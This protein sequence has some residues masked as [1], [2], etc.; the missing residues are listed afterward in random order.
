[1]KDQDMPKA[2]FITSL[3][4]IGLSIFVIVM[5]AQMPKFEHRSANPWSVPGIVP[6]FLGYI[7][8][9]LGLAM[10]IR[11]LKKG[12]Y[13]LGLSKEKVITWVRKP[14]SL[15]LW[16]TILL[17]LFYA[18]GLIGKIPFPLA[19]FLFIAAFTVIFE[20][21]R[22]VERQKRVKKIIVAIILALIASV[23]ISALFQYGFLVRLP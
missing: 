9:F 20:Y 6:G 7:I 18:W 13:N 22:Q 3:V 10:L 11:S 1:M 4:L 5:S 14:A 21:D 8:G 12:G 23:S 2:D 15:R 17:I 19:T 16:L